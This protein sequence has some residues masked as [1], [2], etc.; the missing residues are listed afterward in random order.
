[1][2]ENKSRPKI[3]VNDAL[4]WWKSYVGILQEI[5]WKFLNCVQL[6]SRWGAAFRFRA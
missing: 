2:R 1:M 3:R 6:D 5:E 4:A